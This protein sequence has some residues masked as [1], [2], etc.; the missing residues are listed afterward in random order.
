[1]N[2]LMGFLF[3]G[4]SNPMINHDFPNTI[5]FENKHFDDTCPIYQELKWIKRAKIF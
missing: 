3:R 5:M 4:T 2:I 1:M